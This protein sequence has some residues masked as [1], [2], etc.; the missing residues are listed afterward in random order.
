[1]DHLQDYL[2]QL[3]CQLQGRPPSYTTPNPLW[4]KRKFALVWSAYTN[5]PA[6]DVSEI[7]NQLAACG[8][9]LGDKLPIVEDSTR[10]ETSQEVVQS[11]AADVQRLQ[12]DQDTTVICI[13]HV[14]STTVLTRQ[15]TAQGYTPEWMMSSFLYNDQE[16]N[17][18]VYSND[19]QWAHMIGVSVWNKYTPWNQQPWYAAEHEEN[20]TWN[21]QQN[22]GSESIFQQYDMLLVLASGIQMAGPIL[23]PY[24]FQQALWRTHFPNPASP[25]YEGTAGFNNWGVEDHSF[26]K[27]AALYWWSNQNEGNYGGA[28]YCY[29]HNGL[30]VVIGRF[31]SDP[32][33]YNF[34]QQPCAT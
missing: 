22:V 10:S 5:A 17:E 19:Q 2:G 7:E 1:M 34:Q 12:T 26:V 30:R 24:T 33:Y 28:A 23:T 20:P 11:G 18:A 29:L 8:I 21:F 16:I 25:I 15:S 32:S 9:T 27:D 3:A 13:C 31:P 14:S 4:T 6:P